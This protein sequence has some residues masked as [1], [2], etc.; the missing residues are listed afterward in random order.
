MHPLTW[1]APRPLWRGTT[2][3]VAAPQILRFASDDFMEQLLA[4]LD[5]EPAR[6]SNRIAKPET[7]RTPVS[8]TDMENLPPAYCSLSL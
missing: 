5:Q 7:W 6:L 2:P 1:Q 3:F 4:T 8:E